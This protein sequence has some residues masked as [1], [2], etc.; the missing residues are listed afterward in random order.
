ML[1]RQHK[2]DFTTLIEACG[3]ERAK[4][5]YEGCNKAFAFVNTLIE[6][7]K[8]DC[9]HTPSGRFVAANTP[10]HLDALEAE[11]AARHE[12]FGHAF[13]MVSRSEQ[14]CGTGDGE[15]RRRR[16]HPGTPN[17]ASRACSTTGLPSACGRR[18]RPFIPARKYC[19][20]SANGAG[21]VLQTDRG[22]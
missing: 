20:S 18:V 5:L 1:G 6:R 12:H 8:I 15:I 3:L 7:E 4:D 16:G 14:A 13:H 10:A 19:P 17:R 11:L 21:W 2:L 9:F 22:H